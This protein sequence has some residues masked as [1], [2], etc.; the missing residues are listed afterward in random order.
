MEDQP[1]SEH[2]A[3]AADIMQVVD[4]PSYPKWKKFIPLAA[5]V[6]VALVVG[7]ATG[8]ATTRPTRADAREDLTD[9]QVV[10]SSDSSFLLAM[11]RGWENITAEAN[12][13]VP[14]AN[15][16][17]VVLR[18]KNETGQRLFLLRRLGADKKAGAL[19]SYWLTS[20]R[21]E[22][23]QLSQEAG[24]P[25]APGGTPIASFHMMNPA[26]NPQ[27][28]VGTLVFKGGLYEFSYSTSHDKDS[29]LLLQV[30]GSLREKPKAPP[31]AA[32]PKK[33]AESAPR[34]AAKTKPAAP[35]SK[36]EAPA[37]AGRKS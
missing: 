17:A 9:S 7:F 24:R 1:S 27:V 37:A 23:Q 16:R 32:A 35:K 21:K 22:A 19:M 36:K 13:G 8:K 10:Q 26:Q 34:S 25:A 14:D 3:A 2:A 5:G 20:Q 33:K 15:K 28:T 31:P 6:A 12:S 29:E 30:L 11:P 4:P 18:Q